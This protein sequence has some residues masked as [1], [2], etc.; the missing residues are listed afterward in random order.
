MEIITIVYGRGKKYW[1]DKT[2]YGPLKTPKSAR[3][4]APD[5]QR[6]NLPS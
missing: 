3:L 1:L 6:V 4:K 5:L 2:P